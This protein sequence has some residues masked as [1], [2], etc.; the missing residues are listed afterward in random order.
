[1]TA[2]HR[3]WGRGVA[4]GE[5]GSSG[6]GTPQGPHPQPPPLTL[7]TSLIVW[8][9]IIISNN[10]HK[11]AMATRQR[12]RLPAGVL[13]PH[14]FYNFL[15]PVWDNLHNAAE[16]SV[17]LFTLQKG[18][19]PLFCSQEFLVQLCNCIT[20]YCLLAIRDLENSII[21]VFTVYYSYYTFKL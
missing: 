8:P 21:D 10:M 15:G 16:S 14:H 17:W 7:A 12:L 1:M 20:R 11:A 4:R 9:L 3:L 13:S 6:V 2:K 19:S 18:R 5:D